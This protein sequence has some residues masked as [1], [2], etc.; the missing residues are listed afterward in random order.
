MDN[1]WE[2]QGWEN[3]D[4]H[5]LGL[6]KM[7]FNRQMANVE[8]KTGVYSIRGPRQIGKSSWLKTLLSREVKNGRKCCYLSCEGLADYKDLAEFLRS[9]KTSEVIFLDEI[10]F[11]SQW[12]RAIKHHID[13]GSEQIFVLTGSNAHD[14]RKGIDLMP[15]RWGEGYEMQLLPMLFEEFLEMRHQAGWQSKNRIEALELFF[16]IGGF[17]TAVAEAGEAGKT[18]RKAM[19]T[20][21]RWLKGDIIKLG[22]QEIY[23]KETL[24]QLAKTLTTPISL[25]SLAQKTQMG[26]HHTAQEYVSILEDCFSLRTLYAIDLEEQSYRFRKDKKFYFTD[27]LL[28]W[29]A[30]H[31]SGLKPP[32]DQNAFEKL[33]ELCAHEQLARTKKRFGYFNSRNGEIDFIL[34]GDWAIEV[35]WVDAVTNVSKAFK[36]MVIPSKKI[37]SKANLL[38]LT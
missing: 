36:S 28:Y 38:E 7:P 17:P 21:W 35:K 23:L 29:I 24:G 30:L 16:K 10:S 14:I 12:S 31:E 33:A 4:K 3:E 15:G 13:S 37:W 19:E 34:P 8:L 27:P 5:L 32:S 25:Q 6:K 26:S 20:Y 2:K 18:P 1:F 11:V 22:K 9:T